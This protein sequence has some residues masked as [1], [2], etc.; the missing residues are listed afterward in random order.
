MIIEKRNGL[1]QFVRQQTIGPAIMGH[2][3]I[4]IQEG[5]PDHAREVLNNT[6]GAL[7][8]TGILFPV[9]G[10]QSAVIESDTNVVT[11]D[12]ESDDVAGSQENVTDKDITEDDIVSINQMY[13]NTMGMT[14]CLDNKMSNV[15]EIRI[16][17]EARHYTKIERKDLGGRYGV[18]LEQDLA[19]FKSFI[20]SLG[21]EELIRQRLI[22]HEL[23]DI[24]VLTFSSMSPDETGPLKRKLRDLEK[25]RARI[26][27]SEREGQNLSGY[28]EF[29]FHELRYKVAERVEQVRLA[30]K[31]RDIESIE[32]SIAHLTDLIGIFESRGYGLWKCKV[33]KADI[34]VPTALPTEIKGKVVIDHRQHPKELKDAI[35]V[36]LDKDTHAS[37]SVNL[38]FSK[39]TRK[40]KDDLHLKVQVLNTS[41]VFKVPEGDARYYSAF[42]ELVNQRSFFGVRLSVQ[43]EH[44]IPYKELEVSAGKTVFDEEEVTATLYRQFKDYAIGHGTSVKWDG[45]KKLVETEYIPSF[46]TPGVDPTP[47]RKDKSVEKDGTYVP[48]KVFGDAWFMQ[49]KALS[50][51]SDIDD[52]GTIQGLNDFVDAYSDWID[53]KRAQYVSG[54]FDLIAKQELDKCWQDMERM[55]SNIDKLLAGRN[56]ASNLLCFRLMNT[57]MFMQLWHSINVKNEKIGTYLSDGFTAFDESFYKGSDD[58][59]FGKGVPAAWR[60]FQLAFILLNLDGIFQRDDDPSW[61]K[62]NNLVDLVWFPT[63]GGKT[64]AYLGII[65]LTILHRR[66]TFQAR[67]GGTAVLMRYTLRLLTLQQFQR[68]TLLIMAL[69]LLR[70]W[71]MY[72]LGT[73]PIYIGLWVGQ[74]SLPNTL[75]ELEKEYKDIQTS[76]N[77]GQHTSSSKIPFT[78]CPW[79]GHELRPISIEKV[80]EKKKTYDYNRVYL[81]C[82][83]PD[84]KCSFSVPIRQ[85]LQRPDH[86]PI[87]VSLCDEEIFQHPPALLFGTVDKFA[88]LAHK[89]SEDPDSRHKDSRRIFGVGDW[90]SGKLPKGGHYLSPD[91]IIQDELH[92]LLGPLG[93]SVALFESAIDQLCTR[94]QNGRPLRPK[95]ISSTATT[96]NTGLQIMALFDRELN[97]FPKPGIECDDSFY[98]FY[99]RETPT[100]DG[101]HPIYL[102]KRRYIGILPTG[103]TQMW[104]QMRLSAILMVHRAIFESAGLGKDG[105]PLITPYQDD[106]VKTMD[107][108]HT[109]LTYFNSLKEVGKTESQID[110]YIIKEIRK[111]FNMVLRP[112]KMMHALYTYSLTSGELTGR[113]SGEE[114]KKELDKVS[115]KWLPGDRFVHLNDKGERRNGTALPDIVVA[116]NMISVGIDISRFNTIIINSMP[117]NLAEYIQASSRVARDT[118]GLVFTVHHPFRARDISHYEKFIEF[119]EKMYS[120]VEP[121]SITPFTKKAVSRYLSLYLATMLRHRTVFV[122]RGSAGSIS[123]MSE[124]QIDHLLQQ[125][126]AYFSIREERLSSIPNIDPLIK[127]LLL[128]ENVKDIEHKLAQAL[129]SW[130]ELSD[131]I[132]IEGR[133]LVFTSKRPPQEQLY[134]DID[135][136]EANI[137]SPDWQVPQ[138]LRVIEPEA[139]IKIKS[140]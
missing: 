40:K 84:Y 2:R 112:G 140:K 29:L 101:S 48:A 37:L 47:R 49:F 53:R 55:R 135:E 71:R 116:T 102:S 122:P 130:K 43:S 38:Q 36:E 125:L 110:T 94:E 9:D 106:L 52:T 17:L 88:Q 62:R 86:G 13:P 119:H 50:T 134:V 28:K 92:L 117:R 66:R 34:K 25:D 46:D 73:E 70:R 60:P 7:Y 75:E 113:L 87:P 97:L 98:A 16:T 6:P 21:P 56:N 78:K 30:G 1:E 26:L 79:C 95:V 120:Y 111:V 67:G 80:T 105:F 32:C 45:I 91:L 139:V 64:E 128:K 39:N 8:S 41:T 99:E 132:R 131:R 57:A 82:S 124:Q 65:A 54:K 58:E 104:M 14:I 10:S 85:K 23:N 35:K 81:R 3:F 72:D 90:E 126:V 96:R 137:H 51:L 109:M 138:S 15:N 74:G 77:K 133:P 107:N 136:Y 115:L 118:Y 103:R 89:V 129:R 5:S 42:N 108:Y 59:L 93:S 20:D 31:I 22:I 69:E 123:D 61:D 83:R 100:S 44:I 11:E 18:L 121:I 33:Y 24:A 68:A 127:H 114:V 63:G 19:T 12:M 4:D 76:Q 27:G